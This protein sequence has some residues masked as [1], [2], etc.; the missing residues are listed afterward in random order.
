MAAGGNNAELV[1]SRS[2]ADHQEAAQGIQSESHEAFLAR[3]RIVSGQ[4]TRVLENGHGVS[5]VDAMLFPEVGTR[6]V[7]IPLE[8]SQDECMHNYAYVKRP[9]KPRLV[10]LFEGAAVR[11]VSMERQARVPQVVGYA[12]TCT[13]R[14]RRAYMVKGAGH[15]QEYTIRWARRA[16][17]NDVDRATSASTACWAAR[18]TCALWIR[19]WCVAGEIHARLGMNEQRRYSPN[20]DTQRQGAGRQATE[21]SGLRRNVVKRHGFENRREGLGYGG[22]PGADRKNCPNQSEGRSHAFR[23]WQHSLKR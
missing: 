5:E 11:P 18:P 15:G 14:K 22:H 13:A 19:A 6:L 10:R 4:G 8:R 23:S 20:Q 12:P 2:P 16:R 9:G 3:M 17:R 7:R 21:S 1:V